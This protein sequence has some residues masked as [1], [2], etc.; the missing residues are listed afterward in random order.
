M[1][2]FILLMG[3]QGAGKGTQAAKLVET[4]G[5]PHVTTGGL[6]RA[7]KELDTPLAREIQA[8][9]AAGNL[10][11]DHITVQVVRDRLAKADAA[12]GV[13]FDGFP[14]TTPQAEALEGLLSEIGGKVNI[15]I[16]LELAKD[17]AV[18]R[19][20][21]RWQCSVND[22]HIY[23]VLENPPKVEGICDIDGGKLFQR[24]DDTPEAAEKRIALYFEQTAPLIEFYRARGVLREVNADQPI[25]AVTRD[26]LSVIEAVKKA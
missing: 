8:I 6:F 16:N 22:Q 2:I 21:S 18:K 25:E 14:R 26:L 12:N 10:V 9:M 23:N 7:M 11:P 3:V 4:L 15:A 1:A 19:L 13:I 17:I 5:L 20:S 24:P